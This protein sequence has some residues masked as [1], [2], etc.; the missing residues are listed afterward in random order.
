MFWRQ[1]SLKRL[2]YAQSLILA[3]QSI[4][5]II[6]QQITTN[7]EQSDDKS[8]NQ[9]DDMLK[10][11]HLLALL[12]LVHYILGPFAITIFGYLLR[13]M[14][15]RFLF[16]ITAFSKVSFLLLSYLIFEKY[17]Y[18]KLM[19][20]GEILLAPS[21]SL[22]LLT[23]NYYVN[24]ISKFDNKGLFYG[25]AYTM[26]CSA[27][28]ISGLYLGIFSKANEP[29]KNDAQILTLIIIEFGLCFLFW[30]VQENNYQRNNKVNS[31]ILPMDRFS[32]AEMCI[33]QEECAR[34][35]RFSTSM[36]TLIEI[37]PSIPYFKK[38]LPLIISIGFLQVNNSV[39]KSL[40]SVFSLPYEASQNQ[41]LESDN[42][43]HLQYYKGSGM[44]V[45]S[46]ITA[47]LSDSIGNMRIIRLSQRFSFIFLSTIFTILILR[48]I[49]K[50]KLEDPFVQMYLFVQGLMFAN[51]LTTLCSEIANQYDEYPQIIAIFIWIY[52]LTYG[53]TTQMLWL[54]ID[55]SII[56]IIV[57]GFLLFVTIVYI[58]QN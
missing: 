38:K 9:D 29:N 30:F 27:G 45:G 15:F 31:S 44:I 51:L 2:F 21:Q 28:F 49:Y 43:N 53:L 17:N 56:I 41:Q 19:Y 33:L 12:E 6:K 34:S 13:K 4:T 50:F 52:C 22:Y 23:F 32:T 54:P 11:Q 5:M 46:L 39:K 58:I 48:E 7:F 36:H 24:H 55:I 20:L 10:Q 18:T 14:M 8:Y 47:L 1:S 16:F 37:F 42:H 26:F 57:I 35:T 3:V 25:I 40:I